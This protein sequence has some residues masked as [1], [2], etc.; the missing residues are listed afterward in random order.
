MGTM[1]TESLYAVVLVYKVF[2]LCEVAYM[3]KSI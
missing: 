1:L 3:K 2:S